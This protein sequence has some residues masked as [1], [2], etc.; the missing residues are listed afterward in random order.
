MVRESLPE[1]LNQL[2]SDV[3]QM[4]KMVSNAIEMAIDALKRQD[5]QLA[6]EVE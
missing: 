1:E 3:L 6:V 4:G 5:T 2:K